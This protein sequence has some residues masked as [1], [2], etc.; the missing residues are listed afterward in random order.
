MIPKDIKRAWLLDPS[1]SSIQC[2]QLFLVLGISLID[3]LSQMHEQ[4]ERNLETRTIFGYLETLFV[5]QFW[6]DF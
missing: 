1:V 2:I 4:M 5:A 3:E 6:S